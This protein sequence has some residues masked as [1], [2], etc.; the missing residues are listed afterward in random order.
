V[1]SSSKKL[2]IGK[3]RPPVGQPAVT[4]KE[5]SVRILVAERARFHRFIVSRLGSA[6]E[7]DDLLQESLLRALERGHTL[8][9]GERAVAWFYRI[10]RNAITDYYREKQRERGLTDRLWTEIR[11]ADEG[12]IQPPA[13][14]EAAVCACFRGLL[15]TL[16]PRY[17]QVLRRV[18]LHGEDKRTVASDLK[19]TLAT[20]DVVLHRARHALR[21][22]LEIFCGACSRENCLA[23][24]CEV[25]NARRARKV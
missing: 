6:S 11:A 24:A 7:A 15:P 25:R 10:L 21:R 13:D 16:K 9:R 2:K 3:S 17:A 1:E 19:I 4:L 8:R 18:D 5:E 12:H 20:M 14:W 23:C 22:Q